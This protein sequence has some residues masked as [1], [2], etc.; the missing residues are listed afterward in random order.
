MI[1][2][3]R[4]FFFYAYVHMHNNIHVP[5]SMCRCLVNHE[6]GNPSVIQFLSCGSGGVAELA[7]N[8]DDGQYMY[9]L[10]E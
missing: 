1:L 7:S 3:A 9:A 2:L 4:R 5:C 8:L 6:D 10:G